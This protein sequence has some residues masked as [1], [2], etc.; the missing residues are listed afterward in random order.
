MDSNFCSHPL[1][2]PRHTSMICCKCHSRIFYIC[3]YSHS[4]GTG[5]TLDCFHASRISI[6]KKNTNTSHYTFRTRSAYRLY[7][8]WWAHSTYIRKYSRSSHSSRWWL[9]PLCV[10]CRTSPHDSCAIY[11]KNEIHN[12]YT[13]CSLSYWYES[14]KNLGIKKRVATLRLFLRI[15]I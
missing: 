7:H 13:L 6:Y 9:S 8:L 4:S 3:R 2:W 12:R 1:R 14:D 10:Q 5:I 15:T 11:E